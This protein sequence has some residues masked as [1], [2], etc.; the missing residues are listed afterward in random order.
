MIITDDFVMINFPKT[1]S[2]FVRS[3]L[4]QIHH[5]RVH[6]KS[7]LRRLLSKDP[8]FVNLKLP[9]IRTTSFRKGLEDEHGICYQIPEEHRQKKIVSVKR[10]LFDRI[11][12]SYEY[13]DWK[14]APW[15]SEGEIKERF[16]NYPNLGFEDYVHL[17]IEHNPLEVHPEINRKLPIGPLS[18]FF[19]LF[20]FKE[21]FEVLR[22]IDEAYI[23][24]SK[25]KEDMFDVT[26]LDQANLND[27]LHRFLLS[28]G[29]KQK[30]I[31]FI[32]T[33]EKKN[34][35]E[36]NGRTTRDYFADPLLELIKEKEAFLY[37]VFGEYY[38]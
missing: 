10:D 2:T 9:N 34:T 5:A 33:E 19:I 6:H 27:E 4:H 17:L 18:S 22:S 24:S 11:V 38:V 14:K 29:Y 12:S 3:V 32:L 13:M 26:F 25:Y 23:N 36:K 7:P 16:P 15:I 28:N 1:G 35:T 30:E 31:E 20:Y 21:P 8:E 37:K